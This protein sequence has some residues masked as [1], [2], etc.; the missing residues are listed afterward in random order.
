MSLVT[1]I[2]PQL[3]LFVAGIFIL[4]FFMVTKNK[5]RKT[6]SGSAMYYIFVSFMIIVLLWMFLELQRLG[7][8]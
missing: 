6:R 5:M 2:T 1:N 7:M 3:I 4:L 8:I